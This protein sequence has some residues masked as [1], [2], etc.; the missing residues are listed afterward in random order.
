[1]QVKKINL[2]ITMGSLCGLLILILSIVSCSNNKTKE[3]TK[4]A[5]K[6]DGV[7]IDVYIS[8]TNCLAILLDQDGT[9]NRKGTGTLDSLDKDF[10]MGVTKDKPFDSLM[11][12]ISQDLLSYCNKPLL[13][14]DTLKQ[15]FRTKISFG[16][17]DSL[18]EIEYCVN[19]GMNDLPK[20]IKDFIENAIRVTDPWYHTQ[21]ALLPK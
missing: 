10:F 14:C 9:I 3:A 21:T 8:N 4:P 6:Y 17:N 16:N 5:S 20:P 13:S 1:M 12:G 18:C 2:I 11:S 7:T 19:G 15:I